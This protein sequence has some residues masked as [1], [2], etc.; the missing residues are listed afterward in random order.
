MVHF[1]RVRP[2]NVGRIER[3]KCDFQVSKIE[4]ILADARLPGKNEHLVSFKDQS[5][6]FKCL[7]FKKKL[8]GARY[9]YKN[10]D[11][12]LLKAKMPLSSV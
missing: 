11:F 5:T 3:T 12:G 9:L 6:I 1:G 10:E 8:A 2:P 4:K 7:K